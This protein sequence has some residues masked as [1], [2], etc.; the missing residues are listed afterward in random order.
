YVT[1]GIRALVLQQAGHGIDADRAGEAGSVAGPVVAEGDVGL[2][3]AARDVTVL[4]G[5]PL[6]P[7]GRR[8]RLLG[9]RRP[10]RGR[11]RKEK[12]ARRGEVSVRCAACHLKRSLSC[13]VWSAHSSEPCT[14]TGKV[15]VG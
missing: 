11:E 9:A 3:R 12:Q 10:C 5:G 8:G 4:V 6:G 13:R 2:E 7:A 15:S 14:L 1:A